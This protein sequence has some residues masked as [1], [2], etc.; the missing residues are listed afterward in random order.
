MTVIER[1][2]VVRQWRVAPRAAG[3]AWG[4]LR[5]IRETYRSESPVDCCSRLGGTFWDE[6]Q[7]VALGR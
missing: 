7:D 4:A 6:R 2:V 1:S 5:R 3:A